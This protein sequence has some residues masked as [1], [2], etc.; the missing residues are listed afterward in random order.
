MT[1]LTSLMTIIY[2]LYLNYSKD[3]FDSVG[4]EDDDIDV[5]GSYV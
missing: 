2:E 5:E 1:I 4:M 3:M